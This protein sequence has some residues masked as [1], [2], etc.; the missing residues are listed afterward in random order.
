MEKTKLNQTLSQQKA[1]LLDEKIRNRRERHRFNKVEEEISFR[2]EQQKK[3]EK[4]LFT[5]RL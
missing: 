1:E 5:V 4:K 3:D 2:L